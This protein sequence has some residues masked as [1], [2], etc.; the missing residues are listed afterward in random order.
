MGGILGNL[1]TGELGEAE[2]RF[3]HDDFA[4]TCGR[5][6]TQRVRRRRTVRAVGV[7]GGTVL[8]AG[9]VAVAATNVPWS[10]WG[11]AAA[12]GSLDCVTPSPVV[13][14]DGAPTVVSPRAASASVTW[15]D[16]AGAR[17]DLTQHPDGTWWVTRGTE[18][19]VQVE[20]DDDGVVTVESSDGMPA[21][22]ITVLDPLDGERLKPTDMYTVRVISVEVE[23]DCYTPSPA[24]SEGPEVP[25]TASASASP[26]PSPS[27]S[28]AAK[29]DDVVGDSPFECG[30]EFPTESYGTEDLWIDGVTWSDGTDV[31]AAIRSR[32]ADPADANI[33]TP[34]ARVPVVDVHFGRLER[35]AGI[36]GGLWAWTTT[37][38]PTMQGFWEFM[39]DAVSPVH[40]AAAMGRTYVGAVDGT[41]VA[42]GVSHDDSPAPLSII[43]QP[44]GSDRMYLLD[45]TAALVSC[46]AGPVALDNVDL[47]AVAGYSAEYEDGTVDPATYAWLPVG[48]P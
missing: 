20:P 18:Q 44:D 30:F 11:N 14:S 28:L 29:P 9:A 45:P 4:G 5:R 27:P 13:L 24:P 42:V 26:S 22:M 39:P 25:A 2:A 21:V 33:V 23:G 46:T 15:T 38:D 19:P 47:V 37:D 3:A 48:R 16:A 40:V 8:T 43:G 31:E 12:P 36:G 34:T 10:A 32:F 7:G 41:V 6:V 17:V 1:L 35:A